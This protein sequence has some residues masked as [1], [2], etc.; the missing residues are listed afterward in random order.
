MRRHN[1]QIASFVCTN[2]RPGHYELVF[3]NIAAIDEP[4]AVDD[5]YHFLS[6]QILKNPQKWLAGDLLPHMPEAA[7]R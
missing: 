5:I 3:S 7:P 6:A 2:L 1:S 4:Q